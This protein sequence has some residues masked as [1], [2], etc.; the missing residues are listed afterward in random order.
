MK[1]F[2]FNVDRLSLLVYHMFSRSTKNGSVPYRF[3][4]RG[5]LTA[6]GPR[7]TF[8]K[9]G[10]MDNADKIRAIYEAADVDGRRFLMMVLEICAI[11]LNA[12]TAAK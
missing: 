12:T 6:I 3:L 4:G 10:N 8:L 11:A 1:F 9:E 7:L 5:V 2:I